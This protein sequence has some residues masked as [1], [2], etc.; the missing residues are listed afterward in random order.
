MSRGTLKLAIFATFSS[1]F[2]VLTVLLAIYSTSSISVYNSGSKAVVYG[3]SQAE[4]WSPFFPPSL[5]ISVIG[6]LLTGYE[7]FAER[8]KE[9]SRIIRTTFSGKKDNWN[10]YNIFKGKGG[11][12][13]LTILET[14]SVPRQRSEVARITNTDWKEVDRNFRI[15]ESA[16]LIKTTVSKT[17]FPL[18]DLTDEGKD[19]LETISNVVES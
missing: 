3:A 14:L 12:R 11:V 8:R 2:T 1:V 19:L 4:F 9:I 15:L 10:L 6:W 18:Y 13:R 17:P 5:G 7:L 16:N